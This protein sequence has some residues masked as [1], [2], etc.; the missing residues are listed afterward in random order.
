MSFDTPSRRRSAPDAP[1]PNP[2]RK[3][4]RRDHTTN[5]SLPIFGLPYRPILIGLHWDAKTADNKHPN[6]LATKLNATPIATKT[7][8]NCFVMHTPPNQQTSRRMASVRQKGTAAEIAVRKILFN[9]G[10]RYRLNADDLPGKPDIVN[11]KK[12]KL[13]FVHGCFWHGHSNCKKARLPK[14]N[15][16]YWRTKIRKNVER[17]RRVYEKLRERGWYVLIV[18]ECEL[19]NQ[20]AVSQKLT[21]FMANT[22]AP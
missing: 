3:V 18:W 19:S 2:L 1:K 22:Q 13:I 11:R 10:Y 15:Y 17:D 21:H 4:P 12:N 14:T 20:D 5:G 7:S 6:V 9:A 8:T 16:E